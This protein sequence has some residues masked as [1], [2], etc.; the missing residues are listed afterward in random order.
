MLKKK[1][2][3]LRMKVKVVCDRIHKSPE[4]VGIVLVTKGVEIERIREA[5][6]LGHRDFGENRI[7]EWLEKKD[8]LPADIRWH[9][10]GHLQTNKAKHCAGSFHLIHSVD[11]VRLAAALQEAAQKKNLEIACLI[12]ANTSH[13]STKGGASE[14]EMEPLVAE[15]TQMPNLKLLGLMTIG[16]L[17]NDIGAIRSSFKTLRLHRDRMRQKFPEVDWRFLSMGMSS[18]FEIAIEEGANLIRVG[19]AVFGER[20]K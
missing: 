1:L 12:Q 16:P 2:D 3:E 10:I 14:E 13:E 18:D 11:S 9:M 5:Y 19:T 4:S 8:K 6:E 20:K 17:T 7:Q 15:V